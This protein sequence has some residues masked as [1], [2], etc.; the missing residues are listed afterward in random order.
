[1][2]I[3]F[4]IQDE[5]QLEPETGPTPTATYIN[6]KPILAAVDEEQNETPN[7][8]SERVMRAGYVLRREWHDSPCKGEPRFQWTTAYTPQGWYIGDAKIAHR[9][10]VKWGIRP[11]LRTPTSSVCSIG[12]SSKNGK[13][14]G[15]SHRAICGFRIGS[16]CRKGD[17][18]YTP[19]SQG[20]RGHWTAKTV[21]DARQMACDFAEGVS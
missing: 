3:K 7:V 5:P 2:K 20:G 12:F 17:C 1:M 19:R 8:I 21:A 11:E 15:W 13:W 16:K 10:C 6:R 18:H 9:L 4:A 14:Y